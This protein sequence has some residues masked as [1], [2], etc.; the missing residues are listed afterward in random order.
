[1][2]FIPSHILLRFGDLEK[3]SKKNIVWRRVCS[4]RRLELS[5]EVD[6]NINETLQLSSFSE[7]G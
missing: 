2:C 3:C 1:M 4:E 6:Y 7:T 5:A